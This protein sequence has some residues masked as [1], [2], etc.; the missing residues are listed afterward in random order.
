M[1]FPLPLR[2]LLWPLSLLYGAIVRIRVWLYA[3]G[4]LKQKRLKGAVVSVGNLTVGGTGKTPMV[5]WLAERFLSEGKHVAILSRG[6]RGANGTSDEIELMKFRLKDRVT[7]GVGKNRYEEGMRL[8]SQRSIDIFILDDGF[9]HMQ[10]ARDV[11]ILL[12]DSSRPLRNESLLPSGR[13]R[14]PLSGIHRA[15]LVVFTRVTDQ[16]PVKRAIQEFPEF[17]IF[18]ATT[19]LL[20]YRRVATTEGEVA[21]DVEL[22]PQPVFVFCGIGNPEA[23]LADADRWGNCIVGRRIYQDHHSYSEHDLRRLEDSAR[24]AGARALLTTEK[25]AQNLG[26]LN[27]PSL[28]L[29]YCEIDVKIADTEEF[30]KTLKRKLQARNGVAA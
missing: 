30:Q 24:S 4:W 22:P 21:S 14:E 13:L 18:P 20:R 16:L 17:P 8:E 27:F 7:F 2:I 29:F 28:P 1:N 6:Y 19:R 23:F 12:V 5:I 3:R 9:Q 15:D 11:D 25:D 26:D 10:L